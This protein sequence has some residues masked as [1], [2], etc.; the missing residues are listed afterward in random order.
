MD[1]S[2]IET[3]VEELTPSPT[4]TNSTY[5]AVVSRIDSEGTVWVNLA[6]SNME[7]PTASTSSEI[8]PNDDVTVEWRN[9]KLYIVGNTSNPSA[10]VV[11]V[12]AVEQAAN[13]ARTAAQSALQDA[14]IARAA[15]ESAQA[16]A[17]SAHTAAAQAQ[18]AADSA[19]LG[20][21]MV[22]DIV[23][24]L[25]WIGDH[26]T[27]TTDVTPIE[28]KA[29]YKRNQD[30]TYTRIEDT[31]GKSPVSEGWYELD[32][33]IQDF[34]NSHLSLTGTG[35][36]LANMS[37]GWKVLISSGATQEYPAGVYLID[38][39]G[40][41][42][43]ATT[44]TGITFDQRKAF[45]IGNGNAFIYFDPTGNNGQGSITIS[46][47]SIQ[48]GSLTL[49][50]ILNK[51][52]IYDHT[53]EYVRDSNQKPIRAN[54]T[55]FLYRGG[56]DVKTEFEPSSFTWYLKKEEKGTGAVTETLIGTGYTCQV[57]LS[58]CGYGAEIIGKFTVIDEANALTENGSQLTSVDDEQLSV[59]T[60]GDSVR[61]RD[62][63]TSSTTFPTDKLMVVGT[64]DE[65]LVTM[66]TLQDYL[67]VHLKKQV[68][69]NTTAAW[70]AQVQLTSEPDT[71]YIY[72]DHQTDSQGNKIAGIKVGDGN[73]YLIDLPFT[74]AVIMEH[75]DDNVRHITAEERAFWNNK[76][77][78]YLADGDRVIFT[79]A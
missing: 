56:Q 8:E 43:Q 65:H 22:E 51:T 16:D 40:N 7:T 26:S 77:S 38:P 10:G 1:L 27:V 13:Q 72:T 39:S 71:L 52:L 45:T 73:A 23:G 28:G 76:V 12:T 78:C 75:I 58:D 4:S 15:A 6:G 69:F 32:E 46:G 36:Y 74:D 42:A 17:D 41:K 60:T 47:S 44:A 14:G 31:T 62:L 24:V 50:E 35:L 21:S 18:T 25:D 34:I 61:V 3:L 20:L 59:R 67:N 48:M 66:Q 49:D 30:G 37:N 53:Y 79:T 11:R 55:A 29:Y 2:P 68:L 33:A 9:N 19:M 63:S 57:N 70:N 5:S 64:E 54:F